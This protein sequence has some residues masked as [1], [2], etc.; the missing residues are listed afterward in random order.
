[1]VYGTKSAPSYL[2]DPL[3]WLGLNI[4]IIPQRI[5]AAAN[6]LKQLIKQ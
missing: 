5:S 3:F 6:I 4:W 2:P 1:M